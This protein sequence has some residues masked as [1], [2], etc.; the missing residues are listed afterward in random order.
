MNGA[1]WFA[2]GVAFAL[3]VLAPSEQSCCARVSANVRE[4]AV[5]AVGGGL[6][7]GLVGGLGD[8]T[9]LWGAAPALLDTLGVPLDA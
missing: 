4:R 3:V 7:G 1:L 2:G 8:V 5:N 9:G 6:L